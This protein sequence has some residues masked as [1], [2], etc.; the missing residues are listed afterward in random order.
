M[1]IKQAIVEIFII[2]HLFYIQPVYK[3]LSF[4]CQITKQHSGL[5][6]LSLSKNKNYRLKK[7]EFFLCNKSKISVKP[8]INEKP[9]VSK[10]LLEI[11]Y[12]H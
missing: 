8:L 4:G 10:A 12:N 11:F 5:N 7:A 9:I 2:V 6:P 1:I 3:Q